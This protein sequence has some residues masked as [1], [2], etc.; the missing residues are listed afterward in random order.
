[1]NT[2]TTQGRHPFG[3]ATVGF[4]I[5]VPLAW[6]LLLWFHPSVA[7][8]DVYGSLRDQVVTYQIV[9]IGTLF[10]IGLMGVALY[11]LVRDLP[12]RAARVSRLA[13]GPLV[14]F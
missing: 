5:G 12:G 1:M 11:L 3:A 7:P 10:F 4:L 9:H 2:P 13:I 6:A 8:D 14:L